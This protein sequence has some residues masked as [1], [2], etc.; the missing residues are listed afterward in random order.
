[1]VRR[2]PPKKLHPSNLLPFFPEGSTGVV[3]IIGDAVAVTVEDFS[4]VV[5]VLVLVRVVGLADEVVEGVEGV[6]LSVVVEVEVEVEFAVVLV[7][8]AEV[9][10]VEGVA[11]VVVS[12]SGV[13]LVLNFGGI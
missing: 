13:K 9:L 10:G 5:E 1:M 11:E 2:M 3:E 4:V 6:V 7:E 12:F 8:V